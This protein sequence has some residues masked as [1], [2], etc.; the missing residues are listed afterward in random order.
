LGPLGYSRRLLF[1]KWMRDAKINDL[2]EGTGQINRLV[3]ARRILG[4]SSKELKQAALAVRASSAPGRM[5]SFMPC[6]PCA[7]VR[8]PRE[9]PEPWIP[10]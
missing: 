6:S 3:I 5:T 10:R 9:V 8:H 4:Y 2:F 1:E 7:S